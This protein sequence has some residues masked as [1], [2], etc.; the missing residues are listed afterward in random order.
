[1]VWDGVAGISDANNNKAID[2][3]EIDLGLNLN[4]LTVGAN[5]SIRLSAL[6]DKAGA[7]VDVLFLTSHSDYAIYR[8]NLS[9]PVGVFNDYQAAVAN[10]FQQFGSFDPTSVKAVALFVDAS[11]LADLDVQVN[12]LAIST[13]DHGRTLALLGLALLGVAGFRRVTVRA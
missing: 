4:L 11:S 7:A 2:I 13:P 10:P 9:G 3:G 5:P 1:M 12:L 8:V 6:A